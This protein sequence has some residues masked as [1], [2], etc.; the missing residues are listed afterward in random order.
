MISQQL[1][2]YAERK[3]QE[4]EGLLSPIK[5]EL[6]AGLGACS[7]KEA[8]LMKY[9]YGTMPLR[10]VGEYDFSLF[11]SYVRHGLWLY[12]N[13]EWCAA[14]PEDI[15]VHYVLACRVN[16]EDLTD[17]RP[18]FYEKLKDRV[19]GLPLEKAVLEI[20]YW[21]GENATYES[22]DIRTASPM[23]MY[24]SGKGRCG[25]ESTFAVSA[26]RSVGIAARQVYAPRWAHCDDNHAWVEVY[27]NGEWHFFGACEPEE[28]LDKGW[29]TAAA[30]R[31]LLIHSRTFSDFGAAGTQDGLGREGAVFD[32][33]LTKAYTKTTPLRVEVKDAAGNPVRGARVT[34]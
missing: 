18:F 8:V 9:L 17:C 14:L 30:G 7:P 23:T 31:A 10:D 34:L 6:E 16:S 26:C 2:E 21:C 13:V 11:L 22:T 25:E 5:K 3:Y 29:F 1:Q 32:H 19:A 28:S 27:L 15:F 4:R 12:E 20:N 24:R 33:N